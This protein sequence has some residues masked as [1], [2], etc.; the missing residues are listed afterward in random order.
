V[1]RDFGYAI[2]TVLSLQTSLGTNAVLRIIDW[3]PDVAAEE[4]YQA[5]KFAK[6]HR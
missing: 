6:P 3:Q 1:Y 2:L 5:Q 4:K